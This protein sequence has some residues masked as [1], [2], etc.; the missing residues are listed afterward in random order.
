MNIREATRAYERWMGQCTTLVEA[1][2]RDKHR[3]MTRDPFLFFRGTF[4]RWAQ[5][6]PAICAELI[7]APRVLAVGDLHIGSFGTWRD[8]EDRLA[9]GVDDFDESYPMPYTNDLAR[10]AASVKLGIDVG[11][12]SL[13]LKQGCDA[14]LDGYETTLRAGGSALVLAEE[15]HNLRR[16]GFDAIKPPK[17]FWRRLQR[18]PAAHRVG[19][20]LKR[21]F[22]RAL[23]SRS[24]AYKV[25]RRE[26]GLG[27]L[28][29]PRFVAIARW[30][31][32]LIAR[33]AKAL[34][35]SA[36]VWVSGHTG[37]GQPY[38]ER[39]LRHAIRSPDPVQ[40]VIGRWL[41][42]RLSPESNPIDIEQLPK[43][44]DEQ[45]LLH[46]MGTEAANVHIGSRSHIPAIIKDLQR[47]KS[48]WLR[49][50]AKTMAKAVEREWK[51]Y[52]R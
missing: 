29:Q 1:D 35:P 33:E 3:H 43:T 12:L 24:L 51:D 4:Y 18:L 31:G 40:A 21:V 6:W 41:V 11:H 44:R 23:P 47:R 38:Y 36:M 7:H 14:I 19:S 52:R 5:L 32:G 2:L 25:V 9:W 10:L 26:A 20:D 27:S 46:A 48:K 37:K 28:G 16:F 15:H 45:Q 8:G 30:Q 50:A 17:R 13:N 34:V 22:A 42:R 49:V 39:T